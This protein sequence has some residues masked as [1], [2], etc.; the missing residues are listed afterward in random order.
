MKQTEPY[1]AVLTS[2]NWTDYELID[3]GGGAKL[4]RFGKYTFIRPEHQAMWRPVLPQKEWDAAVAVF[5]PGGGEIGGKW[6]SRKTLDPSWNMSYRGLKFNAHLTES[7]HLGLFPEQASQW[8]WIEELIEAADHPLK[9]LNLFAYTGLATLSA[10]RAGALVTH[11]DASKKAIRLARENQALSNLED[12]PVRWIRDDVMSFVQREVRRESKYD[13]L[14]F[15]PPIFGRGPKGEVWEFYRSLPELLEFCKS[16][17]TPQP[18]FVILNAYG[19]RMSALSLHDLIAE[20]MSNYTGETAAG[21]LALVERSA[22]RILSLA[23][24]ARWSAG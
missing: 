23:V 6:V 9:V 24:S 19:V 4:E 1:L 13:G 22:G 16:L 8:D 12:K 20:L 21:E 14:I 3:S 7:R 17:L 5:E 15:D 2:D 18:S 11:V 10:A